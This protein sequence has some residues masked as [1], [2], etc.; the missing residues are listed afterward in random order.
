MK[1]TNATT[2]LAACLLLTCLPDI[3]D[4]RAA[5]GG[6]PLGMFQKAADVGNV[7]VVGSSAY[8]PGTQDYRITGS[9][10]NIW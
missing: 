2:S 4:I 8:D 7:G 10:A 1:R 6:T 3:A 9:G 5:E